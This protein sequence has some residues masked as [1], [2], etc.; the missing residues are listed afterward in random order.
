MLIFEDFKVD[1]GQTAELLTN[2]YIKKCFP[3]SSYTI[4]TISDALL[5][6]RMLA[7]NNRSSSRNKECPFLE[8]QS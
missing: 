2:I 6:F 8:Q 7:R 3:D 1:S 5:V 4:Y